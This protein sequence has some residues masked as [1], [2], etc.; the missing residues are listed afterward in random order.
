MKDNID[1]S[2]IT[3]ESGP[4][5]IYIVLGAFFITEMWQE[6][7]H[8]EDGNQYPVFKVMLQKIDPY[9]Q[10]KYWKGP[11]INH[12][13]NNIQES[14]SQY[15]CPKCGKNSPIAFRDQT[16]MCLNRDCTEFFTANGVQ[17]K[18]HQLEYEE[19]FISWI[20]PFTGDYANIPVIAPPPPG[21][22]IGGYGTELRCR[23]GMVCPN[24]HHC[25]SRVFFSYWKC[26]SC[27]LIHMAEPEPY[28]MAEIEKETQEHTRKLL[29]SKN[30][31]LFK[32]DGTT[33][34]MAT[35][36]GHHGI[37][38][39]S[40]RTSSKGFVTKFS[41]QDERSTRTIYMIFDAASNFIGSLVHER[42]S[43]DMKEALCGAHELWDQ[44]QEPGVTMSFKRNAA[45]CSGS[46]SLSF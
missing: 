14:F 21:K 7:V 23:T 28:P 15:T 43:T 25:D 44:I 2:A 12:N 30:S 24:C 45:R 27:G 17:L 36:E 46:T 34:F 18:R 40:E 9:S 31:T 1:F 3:N 38:A 26:S 32:Q 8:T 41:T 20:K 11:V 10:P 33:I 35:S 42:P 29:N 19:G 39:E 5:V 4:S 6:S 13:I 16:S 22:D 37:E